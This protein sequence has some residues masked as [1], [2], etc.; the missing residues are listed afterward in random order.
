L[1]LLSIYIL[2][3]LTTG[4]GGEEEEEKWCV[5]ASSFPMGMAEATNTTPSVLSKDF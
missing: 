3:H 1:Y 5:L 2:F 4:E